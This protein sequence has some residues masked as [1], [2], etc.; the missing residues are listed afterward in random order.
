[1]WE[2]L[3]KIM[4]KY[5]HEYIIEDEEEREAQWKKWNKY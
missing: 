4:K 5:I 1:M 2:I 3:T